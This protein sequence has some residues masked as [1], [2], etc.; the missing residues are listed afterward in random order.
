MCAY[1]TFFFKQ[2]QQTTETSVTLE[3]ALHE[4]VQQISMTQVVS[5]LEAKAGHSGKVMGHFHPPCITKDTADLNKVE[6]IGQA[7]HSETS[8]KEIIVHSALLTGVLIQTTVHTRH[9]IFLNKCIYF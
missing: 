1:F 2:E 7:Q 4:E 9:N 6:T 8:P 5:D 3:P